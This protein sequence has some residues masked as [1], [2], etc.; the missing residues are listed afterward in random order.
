MQT[1]GRWSVRSSKFNIASSN[2]RQYSQLHEIVFL[3][4]FLSASQT[5]VLRSA[6]FSSS[7]CPVSCVG[8]TAVL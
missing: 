3:N 4:T 1:V 2:G 7:F 6:G 5:G 8:L